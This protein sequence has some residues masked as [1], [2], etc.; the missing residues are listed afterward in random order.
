MCP[1][2]PIKHCVVIAVTPFANFRLLFTTFLL[3]YAA[4]NRSAAHKL[5]S[6]DG[7]LIVTRRAKEGEMNGGLLQ[8]KETPN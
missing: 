5:T 3:D 2:N 1:L 4:T 8:L 6:C 7:K